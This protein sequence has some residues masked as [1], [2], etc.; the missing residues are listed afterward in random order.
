MLAIFP[1]REDDDTFRVFSPDLEGEEPL[2]LSLS[3]SESAPGNYA[4]RDE[5][6]V[7]ARRMDRIDR[8]IE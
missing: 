8:G 7:R 3:R 5:Y 2:F 6:R 1:I 4:I